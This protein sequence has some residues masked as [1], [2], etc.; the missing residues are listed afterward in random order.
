VRNGRDLPLGNCAAAVMIAIVDNEVF[1]IS[2]KS[3]LIKN[4]SNR[5]MLSTCIKWIQ[6]RFMVTVNMSLSTELAADWI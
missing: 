6:I 5:E 3:Q 4:G 1:R 2:I